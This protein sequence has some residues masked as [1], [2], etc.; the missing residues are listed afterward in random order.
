[1]V[2]RPKY[3][4]INDGLKRAATEIA[5]RLHDNLV[6]AI[7]ATMDRGAITSAVVLTIT[8]ID[9]EEKQRAVRV[10]VMPDDQPIGRWELQEPTFTETIYGGS[11]G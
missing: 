5:A 7:A 9:G 3:E 2:D 10:M 1:M 6:D 11:D 4:K 8:I